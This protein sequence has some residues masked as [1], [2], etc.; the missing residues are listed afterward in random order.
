MMKKAIP[1]LIL[2]WLSIPFL[3]AQTI[4][5]LLVQYEEEKP[6]PFI[7]LTEETV[8]PA[9]APGYTLL[10]PQDSIKGMVVLFHSGR[11]TTH[12]GFEQRLYVEA[13]ARHFAALYVTTGNPVEFLFD[14]ASYKQLDRYIGSVVE[15][16]HIPHDR[17]LFGGMSLAGTR[18]LK[19][20]LW[21]AN[22]H[23]AYGLRPR[24]IAICDAPLDFHRFWREGQR[25]IELGL[26]PISA[27]EAKWVNAQ[28][29][30]NLGG[31]PHTAPD[32]YTQYSPFHYSEQADERLR[33]LEGIAVRIYTE[34]DVAWWMANRRRSYYGMNALDAAALI[35]DMQY[36]GH[37]EAEL[38]LT[39]NKGY[40]PDGQRHPHSWSIV[41]NKAL[42]DWF[43]GL[44]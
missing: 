32:A 14:E 31:T 15:A 38:M 9:E 10:L 4:A 12:V 21:C 17:L 35:N 7:R 11:D 18:A 34:P 36:L 20:A 1:I 8:I 28:L 24:A 33:A 30:K 43:S 16:Y 13:V 19:L 26:N 6:E 25:A 27:S 41:D 22:G 44:E 39:N 2:F 37:Q 29:E 3:S 40:R 23:S 5:P 42:I